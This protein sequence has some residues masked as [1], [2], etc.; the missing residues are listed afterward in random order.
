MRECKKKAGYE[1]PALCEGDSRT[2][3][4]VN[5]RFQAKANPLFAA[6][7]LAGWRNYV[8]NSQCLPSRNAGLLPLNISPVTS[9]PM[10]GR[11]G[12]MFRLLTSA[13]RHSESLMPLSVRTA[14]QLIFCISETSD[15][16]TA[17]T[18][19]KFTISAEVE[20]MLSRSH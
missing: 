7:C 4:S 15:D 3:E 13:C 12:K 16:E 20:A 6:F 14:E 19:P 10:N 17:T 1:I 2:P 11:S 18:N 8:V 9:S 5:I